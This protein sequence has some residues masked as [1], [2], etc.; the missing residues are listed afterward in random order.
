[1]LCPIDHLLCNRLIILMNVED[2]LLTICRTAQRKELDFNINLV[3]L[4]TLS[5]TYRIYQ[6]MI[7][8]GFSIVLTD[9]REK[10]HRFKHRRCLSRLVV[11]QFP[12]I[13]IRSCS[14]AEQ[15]LSLVF[16][17]RFVLFLLFLI[18]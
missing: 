18:I 17:F 13:V 16:S 4:V 15:R 3:Q 10:D 14:F 11:L 7:S 9:R 8:S 12:L 6:T 2:V 1:M 5:Q